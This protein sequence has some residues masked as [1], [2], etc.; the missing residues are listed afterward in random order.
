M[1]VSI[2]GES[3]FSSASDVDNLNHPMTADKVAFPKGVSSPQVAGNHVISAKNRPNF[4]RFLNFA[5]DV[6]HAMEASRK[7]RIAFIHA[8]SSLS[9]DDNGEVIYSL[10]K[11]LDFN[12]LD[13]EGL[14]RLIR[15]AMEAIGY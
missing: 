14:L 12:F 15:N 4:V 1:D 2:S 5:Q 11:A 8:K 13:I 7:S 9:G 6:N 3:P 10:K